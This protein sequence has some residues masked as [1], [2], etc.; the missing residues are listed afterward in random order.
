MSENRG[1]DRARQEADRVD[2]KG[3]ERSDPGIR[4]RKKQLGEDKAG[5]GAVEEKIIP[6]DRGSD[7]GAITARRS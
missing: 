4:M 1:S 6:L 3:L 5:D 2:R 7:G